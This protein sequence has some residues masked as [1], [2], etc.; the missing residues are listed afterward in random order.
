M[1][2][3]WRCVYVSAS[4]LPTPFTLFLPRISGGDAVPW[5]QQ[6]TGPLPGKE[7]V[8]SS[9]DAATTV[10]GRLPVTFLSSEIGGLM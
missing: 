8:C 3:L 5:L 7:L 6:L 1:V 10:A 4:L 9:R 2:I